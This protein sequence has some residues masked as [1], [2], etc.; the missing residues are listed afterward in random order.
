[1]LDRCRNKNN[2]AY[3]RYGGRGINVCEEW[4]DYKKFYEWANAHGYCE[5]L[6]I[7]RK[8]NNGN[9]CPENCAWIP[10]EKQP[11]NT[12]RVILLEMDGESHTL[13]EWSDILGIK[14]D[15]IRGR[16]RS[17]MNIKTAL[18]KEIGR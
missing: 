5:G 2:H 10:Q 12:G 9:Y 17:G 16:L 15:T 3:D 6:T 11:T 7:E 8:D 13:K 4:Y 14:K 1:M 18:T